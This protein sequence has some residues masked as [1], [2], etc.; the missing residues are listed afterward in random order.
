MKE[1][2]TKL[3][4]SW[5]VMTSDLRAALAAVRVHIGDEEGLPVLTKVRLRFDPQGILY[6]QATDRYT[7][8]VG[9]VSRWEDHTAY[10]DEVDLDLSA[11]DVKDILAMFPP[12]KDTQYDDRLRIDVH[13]TKVVLVDVSGLVPSGKLI[14]LPVGKPADNYPDLRK[15]LAGAV[16]TATRLQAQARRDG[17]AADTASAEVFTRP[18]MVARFNAAGTAYGDLLVLQRTSEARVGL[19]VTCGESFV[20]LLM[21]V[22]PDEETLGK[23]RDTHRAW[24]RRLPAP[25]LDVPVAMPVPPTQ[26][27]LV[28]EG[29]DTGE[30]P[31]GD[32]A[33]AAFEDHA[34]LRQACELV[35]ATQFPSQSMLGRKLRVGTVKAATLME[36]LEAA[37]IVGPADGSKQ[38]EVL[39]RAGTLTAALLR[40]DQ[41]VGAVPGPAT[42]GQVGE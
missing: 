19:L 24:L 6:V 36:Y 12:V 10:G 25:D 32:G 11:G 4:V 31:P 8:A 16:E 35:V 21:P 29:V 41:A 5:T 37:G 1:P 2:K 42:D 14:E 30:A 28:M 27:P 9:I 38:R 34:L 23:L 40:L 26:D 22:P 7:A 20:G 3:L 13:P 39:Y 15:L 17:W 18:Q 33:L